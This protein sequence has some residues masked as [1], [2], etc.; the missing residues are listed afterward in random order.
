MPELLKAVL[1]HGANPN[2]RV[3]KFPPMPNTRMFKAIDL[4]PVDATP[5]LLAAATYAAGIMRMLAAHGADPLMT[6]HAKNT[7]LS[8]AADVAEGITPA[9]HHP[10]QDDKDGLEPV[11]AAVEIGQ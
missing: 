7:P 4:T 10:E 2:A 3:P 11:A 8:M 6:D 9:V 5:F 1:E